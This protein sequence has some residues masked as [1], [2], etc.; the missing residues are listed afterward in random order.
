MTLK[1]KT[2]TTIRQSI[3]SLS[4]RKIWQKKRIEGWIKKLKQNH[5]LNPFGIITVSMITQQAVRTA[6]LSLTSF[7]PPNSFFRKKLTPLILG[8]M[9]TNQHVSLL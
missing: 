9:R 6:I 7:F 4:Q 5:F 1:G 8:T 3:N 2:S